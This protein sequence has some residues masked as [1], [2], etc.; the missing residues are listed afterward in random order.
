MLRHF[1]AK[2][3][4]CRLNANTFYKNKQYF[5]ALEKYQ[6]AGNIIE[7]EKL[8]VKDKKNV[9]ILRIQKECYLNSALCYMKIKQ[10]DHGIQVLNQ[11]IEKDKDNCK[12]LFLRAKAY[13]NLKK[14]K[15]AY[16]DL[17]NALIIKPNDKV[18][19][20]YF[21]EIKD[22]INKEDSLDPWKPTLHTQLSQSNA[23]T[24]ESQ[25]QTPV[26]KHGERSLPRLLQMALKI[27]KNF[28]FSSNGL[29]VLIAFLVTWY[30]WRNRKYQQ[31]MQIVR[32]F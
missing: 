17:E 27:L 1:F 16:H 32:I 12:A 25:N 6:K 11:I 8:D 13:K 10:F 21:T 29:L 2:A 19:Q 23:S 14:Y 5:D 28:T 18:L 31:L 26:N 20:K 7:R 24:L 3:L 30:L 15:L 9:D 22:L 4:I